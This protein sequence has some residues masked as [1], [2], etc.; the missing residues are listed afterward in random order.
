VTQRP[1]LTIPPGRAA[2]WHQSVG[3]WEILPQ[4]KRIA[5]GNG[6]RLAQPIWELRLNPDYGTMPG[7]PLLEALH[8]VGIVGAKVPIYSGRV[9]KLN[10]YVRVH[11][12][13]FL[14]WVESGPCVVCLVVVLFFSGRR[15]A[16]SITKSGSTAL[17]LRLRRSAK[18]PVSSQSCIV[19]SL[20]YSSSPPTHAVTHARLRTCSESGRKYKRPTHSGR[21]DPMTTPGESALASCV[22]PN[23]TL[24]TV[25]KFILRS[26]WLPRNEYVE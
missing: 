20:R 16:V 11:H 19:A 4:P 10:I 23:C 24:T 7:V 2:D 15:L 9:V 12:S 8:G 25:Q 5:H 17:I 13:F 3:T 14:R 18:L 1:V 21:S 22:L 6:N 26:W